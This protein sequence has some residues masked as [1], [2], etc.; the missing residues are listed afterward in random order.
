MRASWVTADDRAHYWPESA[1]IHIKLVYE[2]GSQ[3]VLGVQAVGKGDVVKRVDVATQLMA[4]GATLAEFAQIEHAYSPAY[5]PAVD[6][7]A[8]A[9]MAAQNQEDGVEAEPPLVPLVEVTDLRLP[10]ERQERPARAAVVH[11][12]AL[13]RP[14]QQPGRPHP[15]GGHGGLRARRAR[16]GSGAAAAGLGSAHPVPGRRAPLAGGRRAQEGPGE[17][18]TEGPSTSAQV[19]PPL[20]RASDP[21]P[22]YCAWR[23]HVPRD[24]RR[25]RAARVSSSGPDP[26]PCARSSLSSKRAPG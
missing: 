3:R 12:V 9:A 4:R 14:A 22:L 25:Q 10:E 7:L 2:P 15:G 11:E 16:G 6:P 24:A 17:G 8:V 23:R 13:E 26:W 18:L 5:A 21:A 19:A 20:R 1:T